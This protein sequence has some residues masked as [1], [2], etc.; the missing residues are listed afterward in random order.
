MPKYETGA[1]AASA[2]RAIAAM[3]S[4]SDPKGAVFTKLQLKSSKQTNTSITLSWTKPSNATQFVVYGNKCGKSNKMEKIG[5]YTGKSKKLTKV[6]GKKIKK[7]TYYKFI[8]VALDKDNNVVST[9]K[10]IHVATKGGKVTNPKSVTVKKGKKAVSSVTVKKGRTVTIKNSVAKVSKKLTLKKHRAVT[11][12]SSNKKI[13]TVT[14]KGK[15]K[16]VKKGTCYIYA[17]AQNGVFKKIKV[18]VK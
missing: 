7:G 15:I 10:I 9:S 3:T 17:Y 11:Y 8:V 14:S 2:E 4:D 5:T 13:A 6:A 12:E 16:G 1:S 18:T